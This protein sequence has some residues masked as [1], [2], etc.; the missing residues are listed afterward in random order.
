MQSKGYYTYHPQIYPRHLYIV[1]G[2]NKYGIVKTF[3]VDS[4]YLDKVAS[5]VDAMTFREVE[6]KV[7]GKLGYLVI[8]SSKKEM[9]MRVICHEAFHVLSGFMDVLPLSRE[10][11][12]GNEHLAYLLDWI[13][14]CI[15]MARFGKGAFKEFESIKQK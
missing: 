14:E 3:D 2:N 13:C 1:I 7:T 4:K 11:D 15:H 10:P 9:T 12:G 5:D 6:N 8:F